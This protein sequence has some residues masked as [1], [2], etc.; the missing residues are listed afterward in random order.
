MSKELT[1]AAAARPWLARG[2]TITD[3]TKQRF[4]FALAELGNEADAAAVAG[5][6]ASG[7]RRHADPEQACFDPEFAEAWANARE[8]F[9]ASL[10][11]A[12]VKR[13]TEGWEEPIIGGEFRDE[14]VAH[15]PMYSDR[16]LEVLL[17]RYDPQYRDRVSIDHTKTVTHQHR[18]DLSA[19]SPAQRKL[20]R[21]LLDAQEAKV[22]DI[23]PDKKEA[24]AETEGAS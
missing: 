7:I 16:L 4:L 8:E 18:L 21:Q 19:L 11:R 24:P 15:K 23:T 12:A 6:S 1:G 5:C 17:K 20:A 22:I 2:A 10:H 13:A 14:V 9:V 3:E